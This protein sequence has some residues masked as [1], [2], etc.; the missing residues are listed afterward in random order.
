MYLEVVHKRKVAEF[1]DDICYSMLLI[2][3][4]VPIESGYGIQEFKSKFADTVLLVLM[5]TT[6]DR[7]S[8]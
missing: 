8:A 7:S 2:F 5:S 4:I 1:G 3:E 6:C